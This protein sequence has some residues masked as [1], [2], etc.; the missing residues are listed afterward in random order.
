[1]NYITDTNPKQFK[2]STQEVEEI[3]LKFRPIPS[4]CLGEIRYCFADDCAEANTDVVEGDELTFDVDVKRKP[5]KL[6]FSFIP[7]QDD[8]S[9]MGKCLIDLSSSSDDTYD[10][11]KAV[12]ET[13]DS[14]PSTRRY[15]FKRIS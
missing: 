5:I 3:T 12:L 4:D 8:N 2:C 11:T 13:T 10:D 7:A 9:P 6:F 1:M 15:I 14:F